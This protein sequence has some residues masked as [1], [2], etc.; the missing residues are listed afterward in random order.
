MNY[1]SLVLRV[2]VYH[3][4][5]FEQI[6][7]FQVCFVTFALAHPRPGYLNS[8][9][10]RP[11]ARSNEQEVGG[12]YNEIKLT[13]PRLYT[14]A[15]FY[16]LQGFSGAVSSSFSKYKPLPSQSALSSSHVEPSVDDYDGGVV[17]EKHIYIHVPPQ[18][19]EFV[20]VPEMIPLAPKQVHYKFIFIKTPSPPTP[21]VPVVP[22][23]PQD[24]HKTIVYV[25]VKKPDEQPDIDI[26]TAVPTSPSKPEVYFI[27][28]KTKKEVVGGNSEI[29]AVSDGDGSVIEDGSGL[30]LPLPLEEDSLISSLPVKSLGSSSNFVRPKTSIPVSKYGPSAKK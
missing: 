13:K 24:E 6:Y 10:S 9:P 20:N 3:Q 26:P 16:P 27:K 14:Q 25:L 2:V 7:L 11:S 1:L 5:F 23:Q 8:V 15:I 18:E 4:Q 12:V 17:V 28:Y 19:K 30:P 22:D 29:S 21:V